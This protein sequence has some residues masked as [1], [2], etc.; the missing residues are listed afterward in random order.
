MGREARATDSPRTV[1]GCRVIYF[2]QA[3]GGGLVK[4]GLTES[5]MSSRLSILRG[6]SP[7]PL[8]CLATMPGDSETEASVHRRFARGWSHG[9]W[10]RPAAELLEFIRSN[11]EPYREPPK[12]ARFRRGTPRI[13]GIYCDVRLHAALMAEGERRE[14]GPLALIDEAFREWAGHVGF[15][16][17]PPLSVRSRVSTRN[18]QNTSLAIRTPL[19]WRGWVNR[20]C[21]SLGLS[22]NQA[23][24]AAMRLAVGE[25]SVAGLQAEVS[26]PLPSR[27]CL[28]A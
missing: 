28:P 4:I 18:P 5:S 22:V 20:F 24:R 23:F 14:K 19:D 3:E 25:L 12:F 9:E 6:M 16:P 15:D 7:V 21:D 2:V 10:F 8:T 1:G 13:T 26:G 11:G 17:P 27:E